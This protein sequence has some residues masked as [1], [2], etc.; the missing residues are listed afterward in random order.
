MWKIY[1]VDRYNNTH[2]STWGRLK[3]TEIKVLFIN[4]HKGNHQKA[5]KT[6]VLKIPLRPRSTVLS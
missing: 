5:S 2:S 4:G 3:R 6:I 1:L